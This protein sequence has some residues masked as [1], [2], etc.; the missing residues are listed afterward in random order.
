MRGRGKQDTTLD[1]WWL[2]HGH[3]SLFT[4]AVERFSESKTPVVIDANIFIDL[5]FPG[6]TS[7]K[8]ALALREGWLADE[9]Q[10]CLTHE[11]YAEIG[12][13]GN[14]ERREKAR[15]A[16]SGYVVLPETPG[17]MERIEAKLSSEVFCEPFS[18]QDQSDI[19]QIARTAASGISIFVTQ[20]QEL[21]RRAEGVYDAC[22]VRVVS[23][24]DIIIELDSITRE[25]EYRPVRLSQSLKRRRVLPGEIA[26]LADRFVVDGEGGRNL[27]H[28]IRELLSRP[29][30]CTGTVIENRDRAPIAFLLTE[31]AEGACYRIQLMRTKGES[32]APTLSRW[33]LACALDDA[34]E[35]RASLICVEDSALD[36][37]QKSALLELGFRQTDGAWLKRSVVGISRISDVASLIGM[38]QRSPVVQTAASEFEGLLTNPTQEYSR[39]AL[40]ETEAALHPVKIQELDAELASRDLIGGDEKLLRLENVYYSGASV[41]HSQAPGRVL[42]Y[43]SAGDGRYEGCSSVR[44]CSF[45]EDVKKGSAKELYRQF[46]R[47][48]VYEWADLLKNAKGNPDRTLVALRFSRTELFP[49]PIR[50]PE[51]RRIWQASLGKNFHPQGPRAVPHHM[52]L[53]LYR[54]GTSE[55]K[56][57]LDGK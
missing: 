21:Q 52:F 3:P 36:G 23:P 7:S 8:A 14:A 17:E 33:L 31:T 13:S 32:L 25:S 34:A 53:D 27:R 35:K 20:D 50:L 43:V 28:R 39:S 45:L 57:V 29:H 40:L 51:L 16:V 18:P 22:G 44:A 41:S 26:E 1:I 12:R 42:W 55:T 54:L 6:P 24:T 11:I 49:R 2:D 4:D 30:H 10:L 56:D 38:E 47:L 15:G 46:R 5:E 19:R 9:L 37:D 48:G